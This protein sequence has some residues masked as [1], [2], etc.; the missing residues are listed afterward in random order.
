VNRLTWT[1]IGIF[2][3]TTVA[4]WAILSIGGTGS[5]GLTANEPA[6]RDYRAVTRAE[7]VNLEDTL[8]AKEAARA[9]VED[10]Y[11]H[12]REAELGAFE[13]LTLVITTVREGVVDV[14][15]PAPQF[16]E[17][18]QTEPTE[19][20]T[21]TTEGET[22]TT[23][24]TM[25]EATGRL[26]VD[27][28]G[29][30]VLTENA[31]AVPADRGLAGIDIHAYD[32]FGAPL[33]RTETQSD[34]SWNL[35]VPESVRYVSI[36][37][38]DPDFP[39]SLTLSTA[40]D[41]QELTCDSNSCESGAVGYKPA[42][43]DLA[44]Q[45]SELRGQF[46]TISVEALQTLASYAT[47]DV[48]K[49]AVGE[50]L[51]LEPINAAAQARM[52]T[53]FERQIRDNLLEVQRSVAAA[54]PG[55]L[56]GT[57]P[58]PAA[59]AAAAALVNFALTPNYLYDAAATQLKRDEA[60]DQVADVTTI[61]LPNQNIV[62]RGEP[63]SA[64]HIDAIVATGAASGRPG[65]E[66]GLLAVLGVLVGALGFYLA[67]FRPE[68]WTR[69]RMAALLGLLIVLA[70]VGVR[71]TIT[72]Q[73]SV[74]D[75][76][77]WYALP[78]VVFGLMAAVLFDS[79]IAVLMAV[80]MTVL[81]ATATRD[82]GVA[83][84]AM[85]ST[86]IPVGFVSSLSSRGSYR[87]AVLASSV[88]VA[89]IAS[90]VAWFFHTNPDQ[91]PLDT[92]LQGAGWALGVSLLTAL[93]GLAA[94]QFFESAFDIT[95]S[96]TLLEFTDRNHEALLLLQEKAFGTFNHSL[97]VGTLADAAARAIGADP[98]LARAAAYYHDLGKTENPS[99]FIENQF[100][101]ANPHDDLTPRQ[102]VDIIRKHVSDGVELARKY[103]IPSE[104]AEAIVTHH[105]DGI[106]RFFYEKARLLEGNEAV[107]PDDFR[108]I[109]HRPRSAETAIVMLADSIEAACRA[110]FGE[111]EPTP[112]AIEK[113]VA[114][115]V[116]EKMN[117][118][119]LSDSSLTLG[120]LSRARSAFFEALVGH[121]H[122]RIAYPNFPGS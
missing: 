22:T 47:Q 87:R 88:V 34:G 66:A 55:V 112:Q 122:Q 108:H 64:F 101:A 2:T 72:L 69:P 76:S 63:L 117:D 42:V 81:A 82:P 33:V 67:R 62:L 65:Q 35:Q 75:P 52:L 61:F 44:T 93:L 40:N 39:T 6:S 68:F 73:E 5:T 18:Q 95:T 10:Q 106:M 70:A 56:A 31:E 29:D 102:S 84:F 78:G 36:N 107:D 3:F 97:M 86:M 9:T 83:T 48:F 15:A 120:Q 91:G 110:V 74:Q 119:Q 25:L 50:S 14:A 113:V 4:A 98:L 1:R 115:V 114:R 60:A 53:E 21:T 11:L 19:D 32:A 13:D 46:P 7:V 38:L 17:P 85:F 23:T 16:N 41:L 27:G 96:L 20:T 100:G 58:D 57:V 54:P 71:L 118:G 59:Q 79:R 8:I 94:L 111:E 80:A 28:D 92:M 43:R 51:L 77:A 90:A 89:G 49:A 30:G 37:G 109:G 121:Y 26:F 116:D 104:V 99:Y 105:G 45:V 12:A 103:K 24:V